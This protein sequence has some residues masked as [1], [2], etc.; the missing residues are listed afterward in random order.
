MPT[1]TANLGLTLPTPNVD[2]GWGGTLNS[3]FTIIDNLFAGAGTGTSVGLNVGSAKT[4]TLGGTMIL[5]SGDGTAGA[6]A[7]VSIRGAAKAGTNL[8]GFDLVI[9]APNGTGTG[10]SGG[11]VFRTAPAGISSTSPNTMQS[12]M[13]ITSAGNVG[14]GTASPTVDGKGLQIKNTGGTA[15]LRVSDN[16]GGT[17]FDILQASGAGYVWN[18]DNNVILFG[19]NNAERMR[20][21]SSGNV[22]IGTA[23][24]GNKF[25][26]YGASGVGIAATNSTTGTSS[27]SGVQLAVDSTTGGYL[28]NYS[29]GFLS[30]G[31]GASERMRI[32]SSGNV[33]IGTA[34]PNAK[35]QVAG[36]IRSEAFGGEGGQVELLNAAN[37]SV[38]AIFDVNASDVARILTIPSS[39][40][41]FG[42]ASTERMRIASNGAIGLSGENY[43]TAGQ[44]L[45][46]NGSGGSPSWANAPGISQGTVQTFAAS[47][48]SFTGIPS[49]VKTIVINIAGWDPSGD[50]YIRIGTSSGF[51]TTSYVSS[52]SILSASGTSTQS[53]TAGFLI[54]INATSVVGNGSIRLT[55]LNGNYWVCDYTIGSSGNLVVVGGGGIGLSGVLDRV[56]IVPKGSATF[57]AS[58]SVN[59]NYF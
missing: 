42:T 1:T 51:V 18:R 39:P 2:T 33:G 15:S 48:N 45:T 27:T 12:S 14:I 41:I 50:A 59:I 56:Q 35:L 4:L 24:P 23:S 32:D 31:T 8:T 20:I 5:G 9:D 55:N 13:V 28:W 57:A 10:G 54:N 36:V 44:V 22:G 16:S 6:A 46:S 19:T 3:D 43:G 40:L 47:G 58:G 34:S 21:D 11:L 53:D 52:G 37:N 17:G 49:T 29:V 30:F 38:H 26:V 7:P 25:T